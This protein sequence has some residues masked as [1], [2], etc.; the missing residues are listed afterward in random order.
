MRTQR[1]ARSTLGYPDPAPTRSAFGS[2]PARPNPTVW[3]AQ[4]ARDAP[5]P[6]ATLGAGSRPPPLPDRVE[7]CHL[8][9]TSPPRQRTNVAAVWI[10]IVGCLE[11]NQFSSQD[12]GA[13]QAR[14]QDSPARKR[15]VGW[16]YETEPALAGDTKPRRPT[17][18]SSKCTPSV[19]LAPRWAILT[20]RLRR[21]AF[22]ISPARP[23]PTVW[24]AR[25]AHP[26]GY[27]RAGCCP[28]PLRT[29]WENC[30]TLCD[31]PRPVNA[32]TSQRFGSESSGVWSRI[33]L[34]AETPRAPQA[35][36]QDSPGRS[37]AESGGRLVI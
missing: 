4:C 26:P 30:H 27:A 2:S 11:Q 34:V 17:G 28:L 12:A 32:Q 19:P 29:G 5:D 18:S 23:N 33:S 14:S 21:S 20:P 16:L 15:W 31:P 6:S 8:Y 1:S 3:D 10:R 22:G 9:A 25:R 7:D 24:D 37:V 13:P 36:S 35:R